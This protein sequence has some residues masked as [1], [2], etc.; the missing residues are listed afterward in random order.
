ML[1]TLHGHLLLTESE[2]VQPIVLFNQMVLTKYSCLGRLTSL[3]TKQMPYS[4]C[5]RIV[6]LNGN[7][8]VLF[9]R[10]PMGLLTNS[11]ILLCKCMLDQALL[12]KGLIP[13]K[14]TVYMMPCKKCWMGLQGIIYRR[15]NCKLRL[16]WLLCLSATSIQRLNL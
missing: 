4:G 9:C 3:L 12:C 16:A 5:S 6:S 15:P 8:T 13:W 1:G 10:I 2:M 14:M 7:L 11:M